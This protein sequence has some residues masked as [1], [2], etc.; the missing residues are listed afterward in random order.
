MLRLE[1]LEI[2]GFGPF[3]DKQVLDFP[4]KPGVVVIYG[5][6]MRGKTTLLNAV[7]YA[8]F[9]KVKGR[10]RNHRK[11]HSLSNRD[12]AAQ[13]KYGFSVSLRFNFDGESFELYRGH[14]PRTSNP[15]HDDDYRS[16]VMLRKGGSVLS[17]PEQDRLLAQIFPED[18]SRFFLFDGELLQE[19]EELIINDSEAGPQISAAIERI[20]GVPILKAGRRHLADL[21]SETNRQ[22]ATEATRHQDTESMGVAL[23]QAI[24]IRDAQQ[25]ELVRLNDKASDLARQKSELEAK[26]SADRRSV[27][28][29]ARRQAALE[30]ANA[31]AAKQATLRLEIKRAL[32]GSWRT[33]LRDPVRQAMGEAQRQLQGELD[34]TR[35]ELRRAAIV[36][37]HCD[38]CQQDVD[39][40][41]AEHLKTL[42]AEPSPVGTLS[43]NLR[44]LVGF[45]DQNVSAEIRLLTRQMHEQAVDEQHEHDEAKD[46]LN[47]LAD[48]D[49]NSVRSTQA[50]YA[51]VLEQIGA[52]RTGID[53]QAAELQR[54]SDNVD[55]LLRKLKNTARA[56]LAAIETKAKLLRDCAAI[57]EAAVEDYKSDLRE[58]VEAS[59]TDLF[60]TMTTERVDYERLSINSAYGLTIMHKDGRP[61]DARSAGAE[62]VVALALMGALQKNAPLRGPIV[63]DSPFGRLDDGHTSNVVT[64]LHKMADQVVLLVY[65]AEVGRKRARDLLG[66][67]LVAEY[68]LAKVN[69]RRS[70]IREVR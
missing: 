38:V 56:D 8:F 60:L 53:R 28:L 65:E 52:V 39:D 37:G 13:G 41:Q 70:N 12:L 50:S 5:E 27:D 20:L 67:R 45:D 66:A 19:Y 61:E 30:R 22:S 69:S 51:E 44:S 32:V 16:E 40:H 2:K 14:E 49:Q 24:T 4:D 26:L 48:S 21:V 57:F 25:A 10:G 64:G 42:L 3:A 9:G 59:A 7:R 1:R 11:I 46:L 68:E 36:N 58:R 47:A 31:A 35:S 15:A 54:R 43:A 17:L 55:R 23:Q 62:H 63:M 29:M 33:L 18:I 6:N 34:R